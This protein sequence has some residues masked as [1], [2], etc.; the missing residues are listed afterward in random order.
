M[1]AIMSTLPDAFLACQANFV[2]EERLHQLP[3]P[4]VKFQILPEQRAST[5]K[6]HAIMELIFQILFAYRAQLD[7]PVFLLDVMVVPVHSH[8][9][10]IATESAIQHAAIAMT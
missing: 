3:A 8:V 2:L 7:H 4:E 1:L 9:M 6:F 5:Q 10:A